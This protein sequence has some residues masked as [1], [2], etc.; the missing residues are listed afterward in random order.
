MSI[1][2]DSL[3]KIEK[4]KTLP[5]PLPE[6]SGRLSQPRR[7]KNF[8]NPLFLYAGVALIGIVITGA[9]FHF[10]LSERASV[11]KKGKIVKLKPPALSLNI[12]YPYQHTPV[13]QAQTPSFQEALAS[14]TLNGIFFSQ[15]NGFALI[16][17]Q[18]VK[19]GDSIE[20][21]IVEEIS[22]DKVTLKANGIEITLS[23]SD[24]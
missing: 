11:N 23:T 9:L 7:G 24:R 22:E 17:N 15:E 8:L 20:G 4:E 10:L 21:A 19:V 18:I 2:Y 5:L 1:I 14:F 12:P 13:A 6:I 3:K 16:N